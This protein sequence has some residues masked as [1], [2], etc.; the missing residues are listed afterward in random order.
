ML[1]LRILEKEN[2]EWWLKGTYSVDD[3]RLYDSDE[4]TSSSGKDK[5]FL[6]TKE[7]A[8][9]YDILLTCIVRVKCAD[10]KLMLRNMH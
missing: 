10:R 3:E 5:F 8:E 4:S 9:K 1:L 6:D 2:I 7:V